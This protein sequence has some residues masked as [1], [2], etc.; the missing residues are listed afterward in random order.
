MSHFLVFWVFLSRVFC[1]AQTIECTR[2][3]QIN[4][5]T[6]KIDGKI[7]WSFTCK[8]CGEDCVLQVPVIKVDFSLPMPPCPVQPNKRS[9]TLEYQLWKSSPSHGWVSTSFEGTITL[10]TK[11]INDGT[12]SS[13]RPGGLRRGTRGV[14]GPHA[15]DT[16]LAKV[17]IS[18]SVL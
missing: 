5:Q 12:S 4:K 17:S 3:H 8:L 14:G 10:S 9:H 6:K 1:F 18:A 13:S 16:S 7:P 15:T 2:K 11:T